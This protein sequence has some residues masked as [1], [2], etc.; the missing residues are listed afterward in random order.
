MLASALRKTSILQCEI[1]RVEDTHPALVRPGDCGG[2]I[3]VIGLGEF[4]P[5]SCS[6]PGDEYLRV[7]RTNPLFK[8]IPVQSPRFLKGDLTCLDIIEYMCYHSCVMHATNLDGGWKDKD[9]ALRNATKD[10]QGSV[11]AE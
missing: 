11:D 2:F 4:E 8:R 6:F 9:E 3:T 7:V 1:R 10:S 5:L